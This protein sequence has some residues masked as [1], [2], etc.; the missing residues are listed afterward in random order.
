VEFT[1]A[2]ALQWTARLIGLALFLQTLELLAIRRTLAGG[3]TWDW[4]VIRRDF[5]GFPRFLRHALDVLLDYRGIVAILLVRLIAAAMA[6][7]LF[8]VPSAIV[9]LFG[10]TLLVNLRWR[11]TFNGGSDSMTLIV[12][13]ALSIAL[14]SGSEKVRMG[15]LWYVAI[16][17]CFSYFIAGISKLKEPNWRSG[18]ALAELLRSSHYDIPRRARAV[19]ERPVLCLLASWGVILFECGF[20][21]VFLRPHFAVPLI[22]ACIAFHLVNVYLL[23][24]N[25]FLFAWGAA[26]PAFY[27][28]V[29]ASSKLAR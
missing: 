20:P 1:L 8:E 3:G 19:A 25:R 18:R 10:A 23:G 29:R 21:L 7:F 24:L 2:Q 27:F 5:D 11:G 28:C 14:T 6:M 4:A 13:G 9:I 15:C 16:Q 26:Y 12:L 17:V 22:S